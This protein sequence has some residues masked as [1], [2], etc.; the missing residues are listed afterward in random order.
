MSP[1]T[2]LS[3]L[4]V[5]TSPVPRAVGDVEVAIL[6]KGL[7][8]IGNFPLPQDLWDSVVPEFYQDS[9]RDFSVEESWE[10]GDRVVR[11][12]SRWVSQHV[13]TACAVVWV[14]GVGQ[15]PPLPPIAAHR[16]LGPGW[17]WS[18]STGPASTWAWPPHPR[19]AAVWL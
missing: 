16:D 19:P 12:A 15:G 13:A 2:W 14:V 11:G 5:S 4:H 3:C 10:D 17:G 7:G 8:P 9:L 18:L 6:D 1:D